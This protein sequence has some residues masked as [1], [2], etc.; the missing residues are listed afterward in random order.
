MEKIFKYLNVL[1][2]I[3]TDSKQNSYKHIAID[4]RVHH[5]LKIMATEKGTSI[6]DEVE[7]AVLPVLIAYEKSK[8]DKK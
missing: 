3:V 5:G 7:G 8:K 1:V 2:Y 6:R 4:P